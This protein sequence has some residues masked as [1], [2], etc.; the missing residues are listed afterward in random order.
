MSSDSCRMNVRSRC[1]VR[2]PSW[3]LMPGVSDS[4]ATRRMINAWSA[5]CCESLPKSMIQ[6]VSSTA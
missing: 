3:M 2:N 4:S 5:A 1:E 6:P